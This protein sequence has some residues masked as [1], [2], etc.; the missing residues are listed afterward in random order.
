MN[1][2]YLTVEKV[3]DPLLGKYILR[4]PN[5]E[6]V[7]EFSSLTAHYLHIDENSLDILLDKF[8]QQNWDAF[9]DGYQ[10]ILMKTMSY[11]DLI[12][13]NSYQTLLLGM[14]ISL[15]N[16]YE[17]ISN[18]EQGEGRFDICLK[19]RNAEDPSIII[20]LKYTKDV[21]KDLQDFAH[22][23]CIQITEKQY[24]YPMQKVIKIG[25]AHCGKQ[26]RMY[27]QRD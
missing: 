17:I 25:L 1:A 21:S 23:A 26:A 14:L 6:I 9:L 24:G 16:R 18:R 7:S 19:N 5:K 13:E 20:E 8:L 15:D 10:K 11:F 12:N 2:G 27:V 22:Q 4:I 3:V